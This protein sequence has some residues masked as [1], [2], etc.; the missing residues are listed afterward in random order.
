MLLDV[1]ALEG[2]SVR[3]CP[4]AH[5][6]Q[7]SIGR[8]SSGLHPVRLGRAA[9]APHRGRPDPR[10]LHRECRRR[11]PFGGAAVRDLPPRHDTRRVFHRLRRRPQLG[12]GLVPADAAAGRLLRIRLHAGCNAG[13]GPRDAGGGGRRCC[14]PSS[15]PGS[16]P[17]RS[18]CWRSTCYRSPAARSSNGGVATAASLSVP[19][20]PASQARLIWLLPLC[21]YTGSF[22][23]YLEWGWGQVLWLD[24]EAL[25]TNAPLLADRVHAVLVI[26]WAV[27]SFAWLWLAAAWG[28]FVCVARN[29]RRCASSS[30]CSRQS[31]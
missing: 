26:P 4:R 1:D 10:P 18:S 27:A 19:S 28:A 20:P 29:A 15:S 14:P 22:L 17:A 11:G 5:R 8:P 12:P 13:P 16:C 7:R 25:V 6:R 3:F 9:R 21:W 24:R 2:K 23:K 31:S 30:G